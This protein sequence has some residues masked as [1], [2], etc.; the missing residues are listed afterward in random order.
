MRPADRCLG[1]RLEIIIAA[2]AG[3]RARRA[4]SGTAAAEAHRIFGHEGVGAVVLAETSLGEDQHIALVREDRG[5]VIDDIAAGADNRHIAFAA[6]HARRVVLADRN[7]AAEVGGEIA[8]FHILDGLGHQY[9]VHDVARSADNGLAVGAGIGDG[10][11]GVR[12]C[13]TIRIIGLRDNEHILAAD[14]CGRPG[15][16]EADFA[17]AC[18]CRRGGSERFVHDILGTDQNRPAGADGACVGN[19][20]LGFKKNIVAG[21]DLACR[22][23]LD[24][25]RCRQIQRRDQYVAAVHLLGDVPEHRCVERSDLCLRQRGA[26]LRRAVDIGKGDGVVIQRLALGC[27]VILDIVEKEVLAGRGEC[28]LLQQPVLDKRVGQELQPARIAGAGAELARQ[29]VGRQRVAGQVDRC[30]QQILRGA[31]RVDCIKGA[32]IGQACRGQADGVGDLRIDCHSRSGWQTVLDIP[33]C[34]KHVLA[35]QGA[36]VG[37]CAG[38]RVGQ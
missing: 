28:R 13:A 24:F 3:T 11:A 20:V 7:L 4:G 19:G 23:N 5:C 12:D 25:I 2:A 33:A 8:E 18:R 10:G 21:D 35:A 38:C 9:L 32:E 36:C 6:D 15:R 26:D 30:R 37:C 22:G 31:G 27:L 1:V 16:D 17:A 34:D 29:I 14:R